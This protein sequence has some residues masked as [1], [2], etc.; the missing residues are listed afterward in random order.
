[1]GNYT[2]KNLQV[3]KVNLNTGLFHVSCLMLLARCI[4][5]KFI[6][7]SYLHCDNPKYKCCHLSSLVK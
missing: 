4:I 1:M 3:I 7:Y 6:F 5:H 2:P